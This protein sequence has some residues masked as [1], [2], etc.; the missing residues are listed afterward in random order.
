MFCQL[1]SVHIG[2][3]STRP[4]PNPGKHPRAQT[5]CATSE[6]A[7]RPSPFGVDLRSSHDP[8]PHHR[9][10]FATKITLGRRMLARALDTAVPAAWC[11][12]DEFYGGDQHLRRDLQA[13][14][15]GYVLAVA[16]SHR[17]TAR[18][19]D[20]ALR[21]DLLAPGCP[22]GRGTD[23]RPGPDPRANGT[24]TGPGSPSPHRPTR[25]AGATACSCA[26]ASATANWPSTAAGHPAPSRCGS[27]SGW[28]V[29][30]R[31]SRPASRPARPSAW[32]S[33]RSAAGTRGTGTSPRSCSPTPSS[34]SSPRG[35]ATS[36]P[37]T[38]TGH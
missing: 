14:G 15:V 26:A 23:C 33:R 20:G 12:A 6:P 10:R 5:H 32:T 1:P 22:P 3:W 16:R 34:P 37:A 4:P 11:T 21:A 35:N 9:L 27:W 24:R 13:R 30:G 8:T 36:T 17:V 38:P 28:P 2:R 18:P 7:S 25:P 19:A 29:P 31:T